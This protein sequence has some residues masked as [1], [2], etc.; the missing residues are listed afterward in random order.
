M[1]LQN[2]T[3]VITGAGSGFGEGMAKRFA[4]EG[5]KVVVADINGE[6]ADRVAS[7]IGA[8]AVAIRVDVGNDR[9]PKR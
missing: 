3:A 8:A 9:I 4:A 5:A 1:R 6:A 7:E 2:K